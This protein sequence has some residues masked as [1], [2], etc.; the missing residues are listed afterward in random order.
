MAGKLMEFLPGV[1]AEKCLAALRAAPGKEL[2][3]GKFLSPQSSSA[4]A[5]NC[6]GWFLEK[7]DQLPPFPGVDIS[8]PPVA[9]RLEAEMRFPW[10]GGKHPWLDAAIETRDEL[11][12]VESKRF[13]PF[14]DKK[15]AK[16]ADAY[17]RPV[18]DN[19]MAP[20]RAMLDQLRDKPTL[21]RFLDAAQLV[22]HALGLATQ[23]RRQGKRAILLYLFAEPDAIEGRSIS[24]VHHDAHRGEIAD[25]A[26]A[27][28]SGE[29]GFHAKSY[30]EWLATW[31]INCGEHAVAL[32]QRFLTSS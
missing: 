16:F 30:A 3:S 11:I 21:Y 12:G 6:F 2:E 17:D 9:L 14:R 24:S 18:W 26:Q 7:P 29:V 19:D 8:W 28:I 23:S 13:E 27:V 22:K 4:L 1:P 15:I 20:Y 5:V 31:P 10:S 25:F 32:Q